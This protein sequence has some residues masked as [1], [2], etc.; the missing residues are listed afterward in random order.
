MTYSK[1]EILEMGEAVQIIQ[2]IKSSPNTRE[3]PP[4]Q[5]QKAF[6]LAY[7]VDE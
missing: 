7:D 2:G 5:T 3:L 6:V 1:P 4:H